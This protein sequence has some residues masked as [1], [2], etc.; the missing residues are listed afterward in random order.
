MGNLHSI[1]KALEYVAPGNRVEVSYDPDVLRKMDR[2]VFPGVGGIGHCMAELKRLELDDFIRE[3]VGSRP[4]MG[5]CL[6][7]QALLSHSDENDGVDALDVFPGQVKR[8]ERDAENPQLKIPHM[9]WNQIERE[10]DHRLWADVPA[11]AWF[12][13]VHSYYVAPA[14]SEQVL[15]CTEYGQRFASVLLRDNVFAVQFHPEKSQAAGLCRWT[16]CS[17]ARVSIFAGGPLTRTRHGRS[18]S[19]RAAGASVNSASVSPVASGRK[20]PRCAPLP[21]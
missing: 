7:M 17:G 2:L 18:T 9:G 3:V 13:F 10:R 12:Y 8:F 14:E 11:D 21:T 19:P 4:L 5:I 20:R 16:G 1:A 15:A 6:G